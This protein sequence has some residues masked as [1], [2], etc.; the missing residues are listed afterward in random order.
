MNRKT[1]IGL[2]G[3]IATGK[4]AIMQLAAEQGATTIDADKVGHHVLRMEAV[5]Q[6]IRTTFGDQIFDAAGEVIRPA[7][8]RIVFAD[9]DQLK[10]LEGI[11]HPAIWSEIARRVTACESNVVVIESI[12]LLEGPMKQLCD[13]I[14]VTTCS[15]ETQIAR[16]LEFRGMDEA[17]ARQR[18]AAQSAQAEKIA[19]ADVVFDTNGTMEQ[20]IMQF[21]EAYANLQNHIAANR[22]FEPSGY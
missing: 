3:N 18:V 1:I 13:Q 19:Q 20:T 4:S 17:D 9:P 10:R 12:K 8:G 5:K 6:R 16:L 7:L 2:T 14:W 15:A 22:R 11:T 21:E